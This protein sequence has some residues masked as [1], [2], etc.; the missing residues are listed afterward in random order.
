MKKRKIPLCKLNRNSGSFI[1]NE[2]SYKIL[3]KDEYKRETI[4]I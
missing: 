4:N 1:E 2:F 3:K